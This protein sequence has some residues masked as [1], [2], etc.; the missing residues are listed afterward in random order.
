MQVYIHL[1]N[2]V[3]LIKLEGDLLRYLEQ[4]SVSY[5][6]L[7]VLL[8]SPFKPGDY[9]LKYKS[10]DN[11]YI[12]AI[13]IHYGEFQKIFITEFVPEDGWMD[14]VQDV[15][16][17]DQFACSEKRIQSFTCVVLQHI[18]DNVCS[19]RYLMFTSP[20]V[21]DPHRYKLTDND[22]DT[23]IKQLAAYGIT[24]DTFKAFGAWDINIKLLNWLDFIIDKP[25]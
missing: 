8:G 1:K 13:V 7:P 24:K 18:L 16:C 11:T 17:Q 3:I 10:A 15:L 12:Y 20:D 21:F 9:I 14:L 5:R 22:K 25:R 2:Y 6:V 19:D 23:I 4:E